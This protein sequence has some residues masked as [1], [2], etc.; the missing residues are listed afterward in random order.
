MDMERILKP[1]KSLNEKAVLKLEEAKDQGR[2]VAGVFCTFAPEE[3]IRA[4]GAIPVSLCGKSEVPI[5][6]AEEILPSSLCPLIKSSYGYAYTDTCPFFGAS[7]FIIGETTCD[8]KKK[9]FEYLN[10]IVPTHVM[11]L[12]Y[13]ATDPFAIE[14]WKNEILKLKRILEEKTG[15][16]ISYH[17]IKNQI[18]LL[19]ERRRLLKKIS[20]LM[21]KDVPPLTG[22]EHLYIMES[23]NFAYDTKEYN[24]TLEKLYRDLE[25][26]ENPELKNRKRIL[27]TGCP[28]GI[29][30]DKVLDIAEASGANVV[31]Q[32]NCTGLKSFDRL[33]REDIA[34]VDSLTDYYLN[35]PC[36]CMSPNQGRFSRLVELIKEY[37]I[38]AVIDSTLLNCHPFNVESRK[39]GEVCEDIAG[40]PF[41]HIE[42]DYSLSDTEQIKTRVE[43]FIEML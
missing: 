35:T 18:L 40:T 30:T 38:D 31:V 43:A 28:M 13:S 24:K 39:L 41:L 7:D 9:M 11:Q 36:A 25:N 8:G 21:K 14:M 3:L 32:E 2:L 29:G 16:E 5:P 22:K 19:N 34:P 1:V 12:P 23:K 10:D 4:A 17:D 6:D 37:S 27:I 15:K 33:C 20:G 26:Y 42:S